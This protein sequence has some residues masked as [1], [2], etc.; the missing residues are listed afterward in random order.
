MKTPRD[1]R[2]LKR[3]KAVQALF[4]FSFGQG[5]PTSGLTKEVVNSIGQIDKLIEQSAPQWP[6]EKI[7]KVDLA[8]LR[9][10]VFELAIVKKEPHKVII[11]EAVELAKELGGEKSPGFVNGVLGD[12]L[13][14]IRSTKS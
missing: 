12:I 1:P 3:K 10:A 5:K 13:K 9:L 2:H 8:V 7:N 6:I 11:D 4:S 14:K